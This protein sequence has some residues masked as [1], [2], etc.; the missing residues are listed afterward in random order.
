MTESD[1]TTPG[2]EPETS[3]LILRPVGRVRNKVKEPILAAK[4]DDIELQEK[5]ENMRAKIREIEEMVSEII[6]DDSLAGLL[7]GVEEYSHLVVLYWAH[8]SPAKSRAL[9]KVHPM[10]RR[11][12]PLKGIFSTCSPARPNPVLTTVVRLRERKGN[13]LRVNGLD[14]VDGSPVIDIKPYV[15]EF[16]PQEDVS[17]AGWMQRIQDEL[18]DPGPPGG[19]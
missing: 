17:I 10:G 11:E 4:D 8:H 19:D 5:V 15:K 7:D 6:I 3:S 14:A 12:L 1:K 16:Y 13:I 9:T 18:A 2:G